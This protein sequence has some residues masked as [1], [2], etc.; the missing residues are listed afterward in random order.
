MRAFRAIACSL[1]F[2]LLGVAP[3]SASV[4]EGSTRLRLDADLYGALRESDV[5]VE[6]L[7]PGKAKG[8]TAVLPVS[9]GMLGAAARSGYLFND[10][11]MR[12]RTG[13]RTATL[14]SLTLNLTEEWLSAKIG[15]TQMKV[16]T[17]HGLRTGR[18]GFGSI[19]VLKRLA[20]T[21]RAANALNRALGLNGVFAPGAKL[22]DL[23]TAVHPDELSIAA[24]AFKLT[25]DEAFRTKLQALDV[26]VQPFESTVVGSTPLSVSIPIM[27]GYLTPDLQTG[28]F[29]TEAGFRM[30]Q[31]GP[32]PGVEMPP[33]SELVLGG[34]GIILESK[35]FLGY[36]LAWPSPCSGSGAF[37]TLDF[38]G[39]TATADPGTRTIV[40]PT[41][42]ASLGPSMA[43]CLN[44]NFAKPKGPPVFEAGERVGIFS[45]EL[46]P[47]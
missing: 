47:A 46:Q 6:A 28:F 13:R 43:D 16:A 45:F 1:L 37:A 36:L 40:M 10:G 27:R 19:I 31:G 22:A 8:R 15:A 25:F 44:E 24:G 20:L 39:A 4:G 7:K 29:S 42:V 33:D 30:V 17:T 2:A 18:D 34:T 38:G 14:R 21:T 26:A 12:F 9:S 35:S 3:A 41:A 32:P 5:K 23:R 11:G